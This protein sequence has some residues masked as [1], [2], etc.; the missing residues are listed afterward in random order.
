MH[1]ISVTWEI[2]FFVRTHY[3]QLCS[4]QYYTIMCIKNWRLGRLTTR[5]MSCNVII[6]REN[7]E[8][9]GVVTLTHVADIIFIFILVLCYCRCVNGK[10]ILIIWWTIVLLLLTRIREYKKD[11][12]YRRVS[13]HLM[14]KIALRR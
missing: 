1:V 8:E 9:R 7:R 11:K 12:P 6:E 3:Y 2:S 10:L 13:F 4:E 14:K 5:S